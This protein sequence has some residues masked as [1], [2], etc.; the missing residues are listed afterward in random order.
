MKHAIM[1]L[2]VL[3][4]CMMDVNLLPRSTRVAVV[5]M[6]RL[7]LSPGCLNVTNIIFTNAS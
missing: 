1:H 3:L 6:E 4:F 7:Y 5:I 2:Y